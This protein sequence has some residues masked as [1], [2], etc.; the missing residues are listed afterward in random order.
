MIKEMYKKKRSGIA[1]I[2][3][4]CKMFYKIN[5]LAMGQNFTGGT[6]S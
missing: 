1:T 5:C 2:W 4:R 6:Q 3:I